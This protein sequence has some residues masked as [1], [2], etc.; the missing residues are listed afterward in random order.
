MFQRK[1]LVPVYKISL[2][3]KNN[4]SIPEKVNLKPKI[5]VDSFYIQCYQE[6]VDPNLFWIRTR[7]GSGSTFF[8]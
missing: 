7:T 8:H 4:F 6:H 5:I 3:S 1:L 2:F